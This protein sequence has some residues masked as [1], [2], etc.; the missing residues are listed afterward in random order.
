[1]SFGTAF[2]S[3]FP[4]YAKD[5][6]GG[7][8]GVATLFLALF[9]VG[10]AVG[11]M[12]T[13][14]LSRHRLELGVVPI[15]AA[16]MSVFCAV[17]FFIGQPWAA[18]PTDLIGLGTFFSRPAGW[19]ITATLLIISGFGGLYIVPLYTLIQQRSAPEE[20]GRIV[21]G[22]NIVNALCMVGMSLLLM[23]LQQLGMNAP[24]IFGL[25]AVLN[26]IA[27]VYIFTQVPEFMIRFVVWM[28][29]VVM[30]RV[31]VEGIEDLPKEGGCVVASNHVS[32]ID[33]IIL[34]GAIPRPVHFVMDVS[35]AHLPVVRRFAKQE[36]VIPIASPKRDQITYD[37]AFVSIRK[38]LREGWT[39]G[40]FPEGRLTED[41][42]MDDFRHG[43]EKILERD[44]VPVIPVHLDGLWGSWF[45]RKD[46]PA[47]QKRPRRF[48]APVTVTIGQPIAADQVTA[49][50]LF[51]AVSE[52]ASSSR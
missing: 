26:A 4:T 41:G 7:G 27:A 47:M 1:W 22:N 17:L 6:L 35:F 31:H 20:R 21:A 23:V 36:F 44:P 46:G 24:Q 49:D 2:L 28:V 25:L 10:I 32:Y 43:I 29:S 3:L 51:Q 33:W 19:F 38:K 8:E 37:Q 50:G 16:G 45:S 13:E 42:E 30:Y 18:D 40:I 39:V 5:V 14:K 12:L 9:S 52:L 15:G 34:G 48:W 11:S